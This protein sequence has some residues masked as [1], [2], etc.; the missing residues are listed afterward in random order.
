MSYQAGNVAF[1]C[2]TFWPDVP[3]AFDAELDAAVCE[4]AL[5]QGTLT[6]FCNIAA[7]NATFAV[8]DPN[9]REN[10]IADISGSGNR[11]RM[12]TCAMSLALF[13]SP[14]SNLSSVTDLLNARHGR[15]LLTETTT[16]LHHALKALID[17]QLLV[18]SEYLGG[19]HAS[20]DFVNGV[21]H[22]DLQRTSFPDAHFDVIIRQRSWNTSPT[23]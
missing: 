22:E 19:E 3:S 5:A 8:T 17:P 23:Q 20:G 4:R 10:V 11:H 9:V 14:L 2:E 16:P 12:L 18:T 6:G 15:V 1:F 13:E 7:R 21:R